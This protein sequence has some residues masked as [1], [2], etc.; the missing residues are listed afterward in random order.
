[1]ALMMVISMALHRFCQHLTVPW[2]PFHQALPVRPLLLPLAKVLRMRLWE[3]GAV[4]LLITL[5]RL[6]VSWVTQPLVWFILY[7]IK[8]PPLLLEPPSPFSSPLSCSLSTDCSYF[9]SPWLEHPLPKAPPCL[10]RLPLVGR[11]WGDCRMGP[12]TLGPLPT[13]LFSARTDEISVLWHPSS[14]PHAVLSAREHPD[15]L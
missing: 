3:G 2:P 15:S 10:S 5:Q 4:R 13:W 7:R 11:R 1:M 8:A 6:R 14:P 12:S 9:G